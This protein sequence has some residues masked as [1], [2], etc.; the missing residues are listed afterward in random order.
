[1]PFR[2]K[3]NHTERLQAL[4]EGVKPDRPPVSMWRHFYGDENDSDRFVDVMV[5]WQ[6]RF[7]WDFLK[8]NPKASYHYE[9]WGV[10]MRY[11]P[12]GII[13]PARELFPV[14]TPGD[15]TKIGPLGARH[16]EFAAQLYAIS[17]IRRALP[18]PFRIVM[19]VFNPISV[20]GD[21]VPNDAML[22]SH[23][24]DNPTAVVPALEAIAETF[25]D[26]V[27]EMRNAGADGIFFATTQ[28]ASA[29][30]LT[31][32]E[33]RRYGVAFDRPIW[34]AT[35]ADAFN[36]LHVCDSKNYLSLYADFNAALTNWD[37]SEPTNLNLT[38]GHELLRSPVLGGI[39]HKGD[40]NDTNSDRV[41][42]MARR[43][44]EEHKN[45]PFALGPGCAVP[46]TVPMESIAAVRQ[47]VEF[48]YARM[49]TA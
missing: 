36:V 24:R 10:T 39:G 37:A 9:P 4:A 16:P 40:L 47:S 29:N 25:I 48:A 41:V 46:V 12:D 3:L 32:D 23:L 33:V 2:E 43:V 18:R 14:R 22:V 30:L 21:L 5:G 42:E 27:A 38:E 6:K 44:I 49:R 20:A 15:W 8:I 26:L 13:K 35:G 11:S 19:T 34:E 17:R 1:M 7:D 28:W 45:I 31:A